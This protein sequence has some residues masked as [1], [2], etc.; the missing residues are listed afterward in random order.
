MSEQSSRHSAPGSEG[1]DVIPAARERIISVGGL[2]QSLRRLLRFVRDHDRAAVLRLFHSREAPPAVQFV[3]YGISG[4]GATL[5]HVSVYLA[6]I[7]LLWPH[8]NDPSLN[9]WERAKSTFPPTAIA[10]VFS[11]AF[12][13][14]LNMRWVFTPGRHTPLR[15]LLFFTA[16]NL[17]GALTGT[18]GQAMLVFFL[19]WPKWAALAGFIVPNVLIN[20]V[21]RKF[22]IF[23]K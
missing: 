21:C 23:R 12:A 7:N 4:V 14:W 17:P 8:L 6:L 20:F 9:A 3:K 15:E 19:H 18:L 13:Y 5:V 11:N 10:F 16:V 2:T 22:L 1:S